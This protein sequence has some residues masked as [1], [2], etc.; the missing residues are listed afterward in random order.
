VTNRLSYGT[1][2]FEIPVPQNIDIFH[3]LTATVWTKTTF[4]EKIKRIGGTKGNAFLLLTACSTKGE[5]TVE[6]HTESPK[7]VYRSSK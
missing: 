4:Q 2:S 5:A 7:L 6:F 1:A 3:F